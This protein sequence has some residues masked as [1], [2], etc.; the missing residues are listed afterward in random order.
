MSLIQIADKKRH[1]L[2]E[3]LQIIH[4]D[5]SHQK[6]IEVS[7]YEVENLILDT[8]ELFEMLKK[9]DEIHNWEA[10]INPHSYPFE[11]KQQEI[12]SRFTQAID[13]SESVLR[14]CDQIHTSGKPL[15]HKAELEAA[16]TSFMRMVTNNPS[17]Y[18]TEYFQQFAEKAINDYK[19]GQTEA[20][21]EIKTN[22]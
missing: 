7:V 4:D 13:L 22:G 15:K 14:L 19:S 11:T 16:K 10:A 17:F 8:L 5:L 18:N 2:S 9:C 1:Y 6:D 3:S 12:E 21:D 20:C